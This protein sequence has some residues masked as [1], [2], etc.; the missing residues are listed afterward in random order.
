MSA[1]FVDEAKH[2]LHFSDATNEPQ[3]MLPP[4]QGYENFPLVTL[5]EAVVPLISIVPEVERMTWTAKQCWT[6]PEDGLTNDESASIVLYTLE[7]EPQDKSFHVILNTTLQTA[8][9]KLLRPWFFYLRLI[10][11]SL[12]KI[13]SKSTFLTVHRGVKLDLSTLY[14]IGSTLVWWGFSSCTKSLDV[15]ADERFLGKNGTRTLFNIECYSG[16]SIQNY[17]FYPEEQEV[18]LP[19]ARQFQVMGSLNQGNG[20]YIIHL[21]EIEPDY[22]WIN[23][24]QLSPTASQNTAA[25]ESS[26]TKQSIITLAAVQTPFESA[27]PKLNAKEYFLENEQ[28]ILISSP[29]SPVFTSTNKIHLSSP[30]QQSNTQPIQ[31]AILIPTTTQNT[32]I[33]P[34]YNNLQLQKYIDPL[35]LDPVII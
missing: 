14:P 35:Y 19:P 7:W 20:L 32:L 1:R 34:T 17:S 13:P 24:V 25:N 21:K 9:R 18:L 11:T 2:I 16:K 22:P 5:E 3:R 31:Q 4:I 15:L 8:N 30:A 6:A 23:P 33:V 26:A 29:A 28:P 27:Q 10:M 12:A